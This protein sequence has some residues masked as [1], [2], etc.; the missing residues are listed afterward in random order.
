MSNGRSVAGVV[1]VLACG[2]FI[3]WTA[4]GLARSSGS[5]MMNPTQKSGA[6]YLLH[7]AE[8]LER[9]ALSELES[10]T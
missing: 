4:A 3:A 5:P 8:K 9:E 1:V 6:K 10:T 7:Q 2:G